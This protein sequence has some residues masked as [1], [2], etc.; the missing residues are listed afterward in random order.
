[1]H[2][3]GQSQ[4]GPPHAPPL[5]PPPAPP[6]PPSA[7]HSSNDNTRR[8]W[9]ASHSNLHPIPNHVNVQNRQGPSSMQQQQQRHV[10]RPHGPSLASLQSHPLY[11]TQNAKASRQTPPPCESQAP[12][13]FA[14]TSPPLAPPPCPSHADLEEDYS[15]DSSQ[16]SII[17]KGHRSEVN[18]LPREVKSSLDQGRI[19][20]NAS[21]TDMANTWSPFG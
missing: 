9:G 3:Y 2:H 20:V 1:M 10:N 11:V 13:T 8:A 5:A 15:S 21:S 12:P 14:P 7:P 17:F 18:S 6:L 16:S 19:E 4:S